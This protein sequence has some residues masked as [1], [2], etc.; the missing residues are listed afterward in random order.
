MSR[1]NRALMMFAAGFGTRMKHLTTDRPKP[2]IP[3]AGRP[4]VDHALALALDMGCAPIVANLHYKPDPLRTHLEQQG[5]KTVTEKPDILETGGGLRNALSHLG[6]QP[7]F[8]MNT[9]A[10]WSGPNPLKLLDAA[11]NPDVMD[12]L[13][14]LLPPGQALGHTGKGDFAADTQGQLTRGG[15]MIYGGVQII[16][17]DGLF[18]IQD[19][20]FSLN[21]LWDQM[22]QKGR[23]YGLSYPGKWCDVGNPEG[24]TLA[25]NLVAMP[26]V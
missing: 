9:D 17:T 22:L 21:L 7:V 3:V 15:K 5:V 25:E 16:K 4:L 8:T 11:W 12:A 2:L 10:I 26:D 14:I 24:I 13:L 18:G 23:L 6:T 19:T 1:S 20:K